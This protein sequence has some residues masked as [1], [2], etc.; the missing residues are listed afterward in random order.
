MFD[1]KSKEKVKM[2]ERETRAEN[3]N[4]FNYYFKQKWKLC[5]TL[6]CLFSFITMV[7]FN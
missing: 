4:G 3:E 2:D 6:F 5:V 1:N 7:R